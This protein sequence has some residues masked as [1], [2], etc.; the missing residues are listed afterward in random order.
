MLVAIRDVECSHDRYARSELLR[1]S[2][3][4]D[5]RLR[6]G[7]NV[8]GCLA[9]SRR[10]LKLDALH[11]VVERVRPPG[12]V[13]HRRCDRGQVRQCSDDAIGAAAEDRSRDFGQRNG[14]IFHA[15][16]AT[17]WRI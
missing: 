1:K 6:F 17:A 7:R 16:E 12:Y 2:G 8:A 5:F 10:E 13:V 11:H 15:H 9:H 4:R 3:D 14:L